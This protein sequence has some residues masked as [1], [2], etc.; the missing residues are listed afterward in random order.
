MQ[1]FQLAQKNYSAGYWTRGMLRK[2]VDKGRITVEEF[3]VIVSVPSDA[4][5]PEPAK[6]PAGETEPPADPDAAV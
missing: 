4:E 1:N 5:A 2:L 6:E 3:D